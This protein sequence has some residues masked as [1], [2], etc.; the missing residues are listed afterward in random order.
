MDS[1]ITPGWLAVQ[2]GDTLIVAQPGQR[3][4]CIVF[5]R[6]SRARVVMSAHTPFGDGSWSYSWRVEPPFVDMWVDLQRVADS[7]A[8][9]HIGWVNRTCGDTVLVTP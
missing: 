1:S 2:V 4:R 8:F 7:L 3:S 6:M 9:F 5:N